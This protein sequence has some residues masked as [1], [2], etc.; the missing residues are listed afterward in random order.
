MVLGWGGLYAVM[1]FTTPN[2]GTRW[3]FFFT[4]MLAVTGTALPAMAYFNRRFPTTPP[5][6]SFSI[7]R[8]ALWVG[9]YISLL[10]WLQIGH[11]LS[12]SLAFLL[13]VG[14]ALIEWLLQLRDRAQWKP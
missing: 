2:G 1:V 5:A 9:A 8:Q 3:A 14:L 7:L 11:V 10:L 6:T 12:A 4:L 13:A